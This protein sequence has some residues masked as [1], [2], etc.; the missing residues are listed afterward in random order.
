LKITFMLVGYLPSH[1]RSI[2]KVFG[3]EGSESTAWGA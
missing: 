1:C 3:L 2:C